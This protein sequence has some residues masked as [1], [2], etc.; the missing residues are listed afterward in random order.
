M[1]ELLV[2]SKEG[3]LLESFGAGTAVVISPVKC[4]HYEGA[5]IDLPTGDCAGR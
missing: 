4:I 1:D 3:R 2:A 5:D